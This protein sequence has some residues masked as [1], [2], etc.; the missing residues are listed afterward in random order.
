MGID[1]SQ[2]TAI[3]FDAD[4]TLWVNETYFRKTEEAFGL[5]LSGYETPNQID[6]LL[7]LKEMENLPKYGYGIKGFVLSMIECALEV[8]QGK[9]THSQLNQILQ[10]GKDMIEHPVELLPGVPEVLEKLSKTHRLL[11]LTKGDLLDQERKLER[12]GLDPFFHHVEV[13]SDKQPINYKRLLDH[14]DIDPKNFLMVGNSIK[15]DILPVLQIGAQAIHIPFHT[16]WQH[17]IVSPS[18]DDTFITMDQMLDL[19][20]LIK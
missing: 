15:S 10:W 11:V 4:D 6:Q 18:A 19:L 13:L 5:M 3:G 9:V 17:E 16:T 8:S 14:L 1:L 12:S 2:I 20:T 7:F